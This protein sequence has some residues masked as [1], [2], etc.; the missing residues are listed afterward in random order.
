MTVAWLLTLDLLLNQIFVDSQFQIQF[1]YFSEICILV[2]EQCYNLTNLANILLFSSNNN[3]M[4]QFTDKAQKNCYHNI[5]YLG[6]TSRKTNVNFEAE[7]FPH[8]FGN[9]R[10]FVI[11]WLDCTLAQQNWPEFSISSGQSSCTFKDIFLHSHWIVSNIF[12]H[13]HNCIDNDCTFCPLCLGPK[14][15]PLPLSRTNFSLFRPAISGLNFDMRL[16]LD[17]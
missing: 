14:K 6:L 12:K 15:K 16:H 3:E 17:N 7:F 10:C 1:L 5:R 13:I 8:L 11:I 4:A 2:I 9:F